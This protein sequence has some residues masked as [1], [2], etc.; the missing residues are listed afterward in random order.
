MKPTRTLLVSALLVLIAVAVGVWLYPRLPPEVPTHWDFNGNANG[1]SPRLLAA[2]LPAL[3]V[4][5]VGVLAWVL[6]LISPRRFEIEPF[7][8]T[9][10]TVMLLLQGFLLVIGLCALLTGAGYP[11]PIGLIG[12]FAGGVLLMI[13]GNY[14]GKL[15]K[16][17]FIGIRT[18]WTLA[19]DAV[20][21]R[22]H[23]M[24]GWVFV[25]AGV[26]LV[27]ASFAANPRDVAWWILAIVAAAVVVPCGYSYV[28]Y[29]RLEGHRSQGDQ[30]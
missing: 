12:K 18:P 23:R 15:R 26:A 10:G 7:A 22:T 14:M 2:A 1:W 21:E 27:V 16:N 8:R 19:S 20:W 25:L 6:P 17:F 4:L 11:V 28:V 9:F 13:V 24:G 3:L 5:V 29:R 30:P